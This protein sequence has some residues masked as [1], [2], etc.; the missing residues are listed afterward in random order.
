MGYL[1]RL[2]RNQDSQPS[3]NHLIP[4]KYR[5]Y[6]F[7]KKQLKLDRLKPRAHISYLIK[8]ISTNIFRI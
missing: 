7:I 2:S 1:K 6:L 3:L 4:Y 8:Y 5:A